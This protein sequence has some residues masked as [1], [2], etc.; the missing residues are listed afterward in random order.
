MIWYRP[1]KLNEIWDAVPFNGGVSA[2][3]SHRMKC[4]LDPRYSVC[5]LGCGHAQVKL[6]V[7]TV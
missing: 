1:G 6:I 3:C 2:R 5:V 7:A 4:G